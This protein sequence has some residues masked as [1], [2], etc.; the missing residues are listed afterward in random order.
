MCGTE[1]GQLLPWLLVSIFLVP[2]IFVDLYRV[3]YWPF[4]PYPMYAH[5]KLQSDVRSFQVLAELDDGSNIPVVVSGGAAVMYI[6]NSHISS[7]HTEALKKQVFDDFESFRKIE[8]N[9]RLRNVVRLKLAKVQLNLN[10]KMPFIK[11]DILQVFAYP[12]K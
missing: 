4:S 2:Q 10:K 11:T 5:P 8:N 12:N 7:G 1:R 6:Y 9:P 3:D